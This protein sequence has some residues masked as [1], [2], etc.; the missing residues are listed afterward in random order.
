MAGVLRADPG[1]YGVVS[2][3]GM[4]MSEHVWA[5]YSTRPG[6]VEPPDEAAVQGR[7]DAAGRRAITPTATGP[8]TVVTYTVA[9]DR[10]G[11]PDWGLAICDLP[12]GSR[13]YARMTDPDVL[14]EAEATEWVGTRIRLRDGDA[15]VNIVE[16]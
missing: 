11:A 1:S 10:D 4:H 16:R 15:G 6:A 5:V 14:A 9:H 3:V 12:D 2:G 13:C 8:A 7:L